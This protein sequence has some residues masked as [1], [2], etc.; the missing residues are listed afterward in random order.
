MP[1][2]TPVR[3]PIK[4]PLPGIVGANPRNITAHPRSSWVLWSTS[5]RS[6]SFPSSGAA[7]ARQGA[8]ALEAGQSTNMDGAGADGGSRQQLDGP[9]GDAHCR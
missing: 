7:P 5:P 4:G 3:H 1:K 9:F 2:V 8:E 6:I